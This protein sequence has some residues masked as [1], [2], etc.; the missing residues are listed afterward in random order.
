MRELPP[1]E[2]Q[3]SGVTPP[4]QGFVNFVQRHFHYG[5]LIVFAGF[6]A[7]VISSLSMQG[8]ATYATPLRAEF[9][10]TSAQTAIGR[11]VQAVDSVLGPVSGWLVDRFGARRLMIAGT[12]MYLA[13]FVVLGTMQSLVEFY[14]A[15]LL[16]GL[17]NSLLGLLVVSQLVNSWFTR[18]RSTAM[19]LAVAGFAVSGIFL[20][21][22]IVLA[23]DA[24]GWRNTAIG[25]G[26]LILLIG[27]PIMLLVRSTP[28]ALGLT[29]H[30]SEPASHQQSHP[31]TVGMTFR[32]ALASTSFWVI[33][34]ALTLATIHQAALIVHLFPYLE[35]VE[36]RA[37]AGL[38]LA[39]VNVFNLAGRV[40]G[41]VMGDQMRKG[42]LLAIGAFAS[43]LGLVMLSLWDSQLVLF[44]FPALFGFSWGC[45]TAVSNALF[46]E[47]FGRRA[48]GKIAG[49]AQTFAAVAA[50]ASPFLMGVAIDMVVPYSIMFMIL[51]GCTFVSGCLFWSLKR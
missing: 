41:G 29:A 4:P 46:G 12:V 15:C 20:L 11:S 27:F 19:G 30:G 49:I 16:M 13:A 45:R 28:E 1:D 14:I 10:W 18:K 25:S 6:F 48:F 42:R 36:N 2:T 47:Y 7:Q 51:A 34:A 32:E 39:E 33:T 17:A 22:L 8:L 5:W 44:V 31:S 24:F 26:V 50:I 40:V 21:P 23:Q 3:P 43:S 38:L 37:M 9:G 35:L